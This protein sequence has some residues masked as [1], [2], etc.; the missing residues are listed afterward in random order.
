MIDSFSGKY[1][2]LSNF[3]QV[4]VEYDGITYMNSEAA[5]QAQKTTDRAIRMYLS[6]CTPDM[7]KH[8]GRHINLRNDWEL[9]KDDVMYQI[10]L[11]KFKQNHDC[12]IKLL[13]TGNE[14]LIEGNTWGD[15]YW[16]VCNG[17]G[18]NRLGTILMR[19][20]TELQNCTNREA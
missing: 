10:C 1:F 18:K 4:P 14:K 3:Y 9:I 7:A 15:T 8:K 2:F 12:M 16:G 17:I 6:R 11:C 20:R 13:N 19:V 5:F